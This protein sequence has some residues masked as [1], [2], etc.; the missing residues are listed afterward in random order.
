MRYTN[1][2]SFAE[3]PGNIKL[4]RWKLRKIKKMICI[5]KRERAYFNKQIPA[6]KEYVA[7]GDTQPA[8]VMSVSPLVVSAYSDEMDAVVM[9]RFPDELSR[10][11]KLTIGDRII[12]VNTYR[13]LN[14]NGVVPD[15]FV[16]KN[17]LNRY[18]DC[19]PI[20]PLFISRS[21]KLMHQKL[22]L[23]DE[24]EWQM[25]WQKSQ[26]YASEHPDL[27]RDGFYYLKSANQVTYFK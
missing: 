22:S 24:E 4:S 16:G 23:F 25:V 27:L 14:S 9:L 8:Y 1:P 13:Q 6:I 19:H 11:Y 18:S 2:N 7:F 21:H 12:T 26:E 20:V 3:N 17:Y 5:S 15:V 10:Q